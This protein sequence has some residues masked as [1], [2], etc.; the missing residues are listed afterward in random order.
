MSETF[1]IRARWVVPVEPAGVVL[2]HHAVA[3][4]GDRIEALLPAAEI[5][6]R[7]PEA[8][9]VELAEHVL[10]PGLVNT[11]TH[12]AM[13]LMRGLA[14]DRA[15]LRWLSEH[16]WPAEA[17][18]VS[19]QFVKDGTL[20]ACAEMLRGGIT[21]FNDMYFFPEAALEAAVEAGMRAA[22][23]MIVIEFPSAYASDPDD[24]LQ[25]GLAL[26]DHWR[27]HPLLSFCLAPHAP[28][29]VSDATFSK[30]ATVLGE[31]D[32]PLHIHL[33]ETE[34]EITRSL[35]EHGVRPLE[36][37]RGLGLLGPGLIAV[38]GVHL[39]PEEIE[40][41]AR[42]GSSVVHCP[43]S[44]LKL[45]SGFAPV[46]QLLAAGVNV[47]LGT[48]GAASNN[49][50]DLMQEM[51][52]A[53]LLAKAVARDAE[54][55]PAHLALRCATLGGAVALGLERRVGSIAAGKCADL[56]AVRLLG[57][58]LAPCFDPVSHLVYAAG[59]EHVSDVWV[60]GKQ[61]LRARELLNPL[62]SSLDT[63]TQ[64]WQNALGSRPDS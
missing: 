42:H 13:S 14:D 25:K 46:A 54:A 39:A 49:R 8:E 53:A 43:S 37:L 55:M 17:R 61:Q 45:A 22:L 2:E 21:C 38:H 34:E 27:E 50:L 19:P 7:Y 51:R 41:L 20:L 56:V 26:R 33:H 24:Y 11:H 23:G 58:E 44:N 63:R 29:T 30:L 15:L 18:H 60:A 57:P 28:Y 16:I 47:A 12:A 1:L 40:M 3:V 5:A 64:L 62:M 36:R 4:R 35:A 10:I 9:V 32:V 31:L 59:R 52:Q 6:S 48:D